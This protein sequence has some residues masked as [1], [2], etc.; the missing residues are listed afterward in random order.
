MNELWMRRGVCVLGLLVFLGIA[1]LVSTDRRKMNWRLIGSGL[2]IQLLLGIFLLRTIPGRKVYDAGSNMLS[3]LV[4][5]SN[6]GSSFLFGKELVSQCPALGF[7]PAIIVVSSLTAVLFHLGVL[8]K[9]VW[10]MSKIMVRV[11]DV[12]GSESLAA[13]ANIFVGMTEAPLVVKPYLKTMTRSELMAMMTGGMATSAGGTMA[14]YAF[15]LKEHGVDPGHLLTASL[16]SAPA[17][18][19]LAKILVP[20]T[21]HSLTKGEVAIDIPRKDAN[22]FDAACRGA[23]EGMKLALNVAAMLIA[24]I[25]LIWLVNQGVGWALPDV[26]GEPMSLQRV[27]GWAFAPLAW[28]MGIPWSEALLVGQFLGEKTILNE[29]I[30]YQDMAEH[31]AELSTRSKVIVSYALCGF[32]NFG[33]VAIMIGGVGGLAPERRKEMAELGMRALLGGTLA[34]MMTANIAAL[35]I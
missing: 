8:Q 17:S 18:L 10:L 11:M 4:D 1:W 2:L 34:A 15:I 5:A 6:H 30:A 27:L 28:L 25:A 21:E 26:G 13:S 32:A 29:I 7:L 23:S 31:S 35:L 16:M 9:L 12:S 33:S 24:F 14:I 22:I 20:E 3:L 19:V